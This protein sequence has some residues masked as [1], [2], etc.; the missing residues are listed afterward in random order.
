MSANTELIDR[1]TLEKIV[2]DIKAILRRTSLDALNSVQWEF[3]QRYLFGNEA[4]KPLIKAGK[5]F[6]KEGPVAKGAIWTSLDT[7]KLWMNTG[8]GWKN[9]GGLNNINKPDLIEIFHPRT[10]YPVEE[11]I[12]RTNVGGE[13]W[14][15][16]NF[17]KYEK[18]SLTK[19][20][21]PFT[22]FM[23]RTN[24]SRTDIAQDVR[25]SF[26]SGAGT[27]E[28]ICMVD[29]A[30][31]FCFT[32]GS[33]SN[34]VDITLTDLGSAI[35]PVKVTN[36]T[37]TNRFITFPI[38]KGK[39]YYYT[40]TARS[41]YI[42]YGKGSKSVQNPNNI[43][44]Q[45][46]NS[47]DSGAGTWSFVAEHDADWLYLY[48]GPD[49]VLESFELR[50]EDLPDYVLTYPYVTRSA[51][52]RPE[53]PKVG[54]MIFDAYQAGTSGSPL[55][56]NGTNWVD[57]KA[58]VST[59]ATTDAPVTAN[60]GT[61]YFDLTEGN[62]K[63]WINGGWQDIINV[64]QSARQVL[65][66]NSNIPSVKEGMFRTN[67]STGYYGGVQVYNGKSWQYIQTT[68]DRIFAR[69]VWNN[70]QDGTVGYEADGRLK[71]AYGAIKHTLA[72]IEETHIAQAVTFTN[73]AGETV[74]ANDVEKII[75]TA[76]FG[77]NSI[78]DFSNIT[79]VEGK[80][81]EIMNTANAI[82]SIKDGATTTA[83]TDCN[84]SIVK[85]VCLSD[86]WH[87]YKV[88][89]ITEIVNQS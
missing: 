40:K 15:P 31:Y 58:S 10:D 33:S 67:T 2:A 77:A 60:D 37:E 11:P 70:P 16:Y 87:F 78:L 50:S 24:N 12:V 5:L 4:D 6:T 3:N 65:Y 20:Q 19:T 69:T 85:A 71:F 63:I 1:E 29:D 32:T 9:I 73:S 48:I 57:A 42:G 88:S 82:F 80:T 30:K 28:F 79:K 17:K 53:N 68:A 27:Y 26:S 89:G 34:L 59:L 62:L 56:W 55:W 76:A 61:I 64:V 38:E 49:A 81:I 23:T 13:F 51:N 36:M 86:V 8:A 39:R 22:G 43:L 46:N 14:I 75:V 35:E 74:V 7:G 41:F 54:D 66:N 84:G 21:S 45:V 18:Y 25:T 47:G 83:L 52:D 72:Y 44:K